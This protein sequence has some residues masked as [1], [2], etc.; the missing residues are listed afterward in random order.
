MCPLLLLR[1]EV[2]TLVSH[3]IA[4]PLHRQNILVGLLGSAETPGTLLVHFRPEKIKEINVKS[5]AQKSYDIVK[6]LK[7]KHFGTL[8]TRNE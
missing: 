7:T 5:F 4:Q 3:F 6:R 2:Q 8:H 1:W